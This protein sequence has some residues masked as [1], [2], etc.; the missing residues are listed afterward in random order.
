MA[1]LN[2]NQLRDV[3]DLLL[4]IQRGVSVHLPLIH[5]KMKCPQPF[6]D[7]KEAVIQKISTYDILS[8]LHQIHLPN[9]AEFRIIKD[10][11]VLFNILR[12]WKK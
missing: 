2:R 10:K 3:Y 11:E 8:R 5:E 6:E 7:I 12:D 1:I 9:E 4:Y